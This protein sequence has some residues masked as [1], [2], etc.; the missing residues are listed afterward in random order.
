MKADGILG[1]GLNYSGM[2][3]QPVVQNMIAQKLIN[4]PIFSVFLSND[5][6]KIKS[7]VIFGDFDLK[8]YAESN[9][10]EYLNIV[11]DGY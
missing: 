11:K 9:T 2:F 8:K 10:I 1:M 4:Q 5:D 3:H 7:C 6:S